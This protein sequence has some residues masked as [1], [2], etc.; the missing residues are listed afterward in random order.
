MFSRKKI[1]AV[2]GLLCGLA[3]TCAG[4]TQA[5]AA[6]GPGTCT[7]DSEGNVTCVQRIV[8][9]M[10]EGDGFVVRQAQG[11]VPTKPF[12]LPVIPVLN[13]GSTKIGPEVTC[14]PKAG[15]APDNSDKSD[16]S[17]KSDNGLGLPGLLG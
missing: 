5:Y 9:D 14:S 16:K 4:A 12:S 13:N 11:C 15:S 1:A 6:G 3:V 10:S 7:F 8:G 2:S 17:D